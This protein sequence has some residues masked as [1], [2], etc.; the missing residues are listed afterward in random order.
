IIHQ[1]LYACEQWQQKADRVAA[2]KRKGGN[3]K[4]MNRWDRQKKD[5][6]E[7]YYECERSRPK[8]HAVSKSPPKKRNIKPERQKMRVSSSENPVTQQLL[9]TCNFWITTANRNPTA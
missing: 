6:A 7:R 9:S 4:Q 8:I 1:P 5:Y 2:L 3:A